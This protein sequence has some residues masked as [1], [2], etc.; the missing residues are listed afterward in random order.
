M[1]AIAEK[2]H[3]DT[4]EAS[5]RWS[6]IQGG[7]YGASKRT[8]ERAVSD[9]KT[10]RLITVVKPGFDNGH[11]Y[12]RAPIYRI[13]RL[14]DA[15]TAMS[16]SPPT[17]TDNRYTD[18]DKR[19]TDTD[20]AVSYLTVP[21]DGSLDGVTHLSNADDTSALANDEP[22]PDEPPD[23]DQPP[24]R[25]AFDA[26]EM[27]EDWWPSE[28]VM[29]QMRDETGRGREWL[30]YWAEWLRDDRWADG[31]PQDPRCPSWDDE[32]RSR[33]RW[34]HKN[35]QGPPSG[36]AGFRSASGGLDD[37]EP[38]DLSRLFDIPTQPRR[39]EVIDA[40]VI[41]SDDGWAAS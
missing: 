18:T 11:G 28:R 14:P 17:D 16:V 22:L 20:T 31:R 15:D 9:L 13:E 23:D 32:Y 2:A 30:D 37:S 6:H 21:Y 35:D 24:E 12:A 4:R 40:E 19:R 41:D 39:P 25:V 29:A 3:G 36:P 1:I 5:V 10:A 8:A 26:L 33:V 27:T 38:F 34:A 7:L